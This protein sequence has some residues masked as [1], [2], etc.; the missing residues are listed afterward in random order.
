MW[1]L[2]LILLMFHCAIFYMSWRRSSMVYTYT[3]VPPVKTIAQMNAQFQEIYG[4]LNLI[5]S[6]GVG[7]GSYDYLTIK[8][9]AVYE[10]YNS[11]ATLVYGGASDAGGIEG[12]N[13]EDV[14]QACIDNGGAGAS[15]GFLGTLTVASDGIDMDTANQTLF[16]FGW[17]SQLTQPNGA[18]VDILIDV[19]AS[20]ITHDNFYLEGNYANNTDTIA[21][22][23][24]HAD[25][26]YYTLRNC[27][28]THFPE[29]L[30]YLSTNNNVFNIH[31]NYITESTN[32]NAIFCSGSA[33]GFIHHNSLGGCANATNG[34][35]RSSTLGSTN[36]CNNKLF[37][38]AEYY[39]Y[40]DSAVK[41]NICNNIIGGSA[42]MGTK[43]LIYMVCSAAAYGKYNIIADNILYSD[44]S[45]NRYGICL[46]GSEMLYNDI[47][48][49][50]LYNFDDAALIELSSADYNQWHDNSCYNCTTPIS[51]YGHNSVWRHNANAN[52]G[53]VANEF[54]AA[55]N[56]I[57]PKWGNASNPVASTDYTV[58]NVDIFIYSSDSGN[59]DCS[60]SIDNDN[61]DLIATG[62]S[63]L[64]G[65]FVPV[66]FT[67][68]WGAF[69]GANPTVNIAFLGG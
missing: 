49:N 11:Q 63:T 48:D 35:L 15:I 33:D 22:K 68:N 2:V 59:T 58:E 24:S 14:L 26:D 30:V 10:A 25:A 54:V 32:G 27:V 40:L 17:G 66:G 6:T 36:I 4:A 61:G 38:T 37:G 18:D 64:D 28:V 19:S 8:N 9:G 45:D 44:G 42:P 5:T 65:V 51:L 46:T 3:P 31:N 16:G 23:L 20:G 29:H 12:D 67:I 39:M 62:L 60:I 47:H 50:Q 43:D 55:S 7:A 41:C 52:L 34:I 53:T 13:A 57:T 56:I 1:S 69:T 21:I